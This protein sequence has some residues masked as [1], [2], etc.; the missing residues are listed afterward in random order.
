MRHGSCSFLGTWLLFNFIIFSRLPVVTTVKIDASANRGLLYLGPYSFR[1]LAR[2]VVHKKDTTIR[3]VGGEGMSNGRLEIQIHNNW[4]AVLLEHF[5]LRGAAVACTQL[6]F[7][8]NGGVS[9]YTYSGEE[10][11]EMTGEKS[12]TSVIATSIIAANVRCNGTE[13][14]LQTCS[15]RFG[16]NTS[17]TISNIRTAKLV[18]IRCPTIRISREVDG[19]TYG[20][21]DHMLFIF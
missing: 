3:V 6:G 14:A 4:G 21:R 15:G 19:L 1:Q 5:D 20:V 17:S 16:K 7:G 2:K 11:Q 10:Q 8:T 18:G 12:T 9:I 13:N